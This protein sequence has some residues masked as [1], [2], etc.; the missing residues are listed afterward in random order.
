M[1][2]SL[3][4]YRREN[5]NESAMIPGAFRFLFPFFHLGFLDGTT[6]LRLVSSRLDRVAPPRPLAAFISIT[7]SRLSAVAR[8]LV[9]SNAASAAP[10][11]AKRSSCPRRY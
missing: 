9:L 8:E 5:Y 1:S 11:A 2:H 10:A 3:A 4:R 6:S 7:M